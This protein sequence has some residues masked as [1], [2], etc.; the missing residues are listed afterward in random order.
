VGISW[1]LCWRPS[2]YCHCDYFQWKSGCKVSHV[3]YHRSFGT[4]PA[5]NR[6]KWISYSQSSVFWNLRCVVANLQQSSHGDSVERSKCCPGRSMHLCYASRS[7]TQDRPYQECHGN[8]VSSRLGRH[9]WV[10][11]LLDPDL[12]LSRHSHSKGLLSPIS[13]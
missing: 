9:D 8:R 12:L 3:R 7:Y 1:L 4:L 10:W 13:T 5:N 2:S 6:K 11:H